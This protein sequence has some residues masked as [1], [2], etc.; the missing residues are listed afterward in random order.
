MITG[1]NTSKILI[2]HIHVT[3]DV[4]LIVGNTIQSKNWITIIINAVVKKKQNIT[5]TKK[6]IL[7][8]VA[9]ALVNVIVIVRFMNI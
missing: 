4:N 2:K 8:I 9:Y 1:I 3:V 5:N 7:G 6:I